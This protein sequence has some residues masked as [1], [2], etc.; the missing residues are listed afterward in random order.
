MK[1]FF[2]T[3]FILCMSLFSLPALSNELSWETKELLL[4]KLQT[5]T[6]VVY[7]KD[8]EITTFNERG[9]EPVLIYLK[10]DN[11]KDS[12]VFDKT[13]GRAAAYLYVYGDAEFV[14]ADTMSKPAIKILKKHHIK[15]ESP[16]IVKEIQNRDKTD[17]CPFEK[18]TKKV[19]NAN[20]AY[21][22][23]YNKVYK[24]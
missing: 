10:N 1:R 2:T 23:I 14:Y 5:S 21:K 15:Y 16:N 12:Y 17:L 3:C 24:L 7:N 8:G 18:L 6:L 11:F 19:K 13:V 20:E 22:L 9:L 4:E